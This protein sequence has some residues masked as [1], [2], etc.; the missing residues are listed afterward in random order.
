MARV[1]R[2]APRHARCAQAAP[3]SSAPTL[4]PVWLSFNIE[5]HYWD[6]MVRIAQDGVWP[7]SD[8]HAQRQPI[9]PQLRAHAAAT[10]G[11]CPPNNPSHP[12]VVHIARQG[13]VQQGHGGSAILGRSCR[14]DLAPAKHDRHPIVGPRPVCQ[15]RSQRLGL[16]LAC[17]RACAGAGGDCG[18][19][20]GC[21]WGGVGWGGGA[22][23]PSSGQ[24]WAMRGA[25]QDVLTLIQRVSQAMLDYKTSCLQT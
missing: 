22:P 21:A 16:A 11:T 18:G 20:G 12:H 6:A 13:Q 5:M 7:A 10:G 15:H 14:R 23:R 25:R 9:V 19:W 8:S 17:Q 4:G 3:C 2:F 24:D 1:E